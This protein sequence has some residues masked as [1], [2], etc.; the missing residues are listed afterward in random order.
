MTPARPANWWGQALKAFLLILAVSSSSSPL[1]AIVRAS[2]EPAHPTNQQTVTFVAVSPGAQRITLGFEL[3]RLSQNPNGSRQQ[4]QVSAFREVATCQAPSNG[5]CRHPMASAFPAASLVRFRATAVNAQGLSET[6]T[7]DFAAGAY[8]WPE[9]PIPVRVKG[10]PIDRF[11]VVFI[12]DRDI[13]VESF[14]SQ[15]TSVVRDRYFKYPIIETGRGFYNFYYSGQQGDYENG[16]A[17]TNP[18]NMANL[19]AVADAV[20]FLH[21]ADL[22]DCKFGR[23]VSSE[24]NNDKSMIHETGH[25]LFGLQD[26]YCC[27]S[28]YSPQACVPNLWS[29]EQRCKTAAP[30][31]G[32]PANSCVQLAEG[33]AK[34]AL[35]RIGSDG[36]AGCI[37]GPSQHRPGSNFGRACMRRINRKYSRC[38]AGDCSQSECD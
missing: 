1:G 17:F 15:L 3:F 12:P 5:E 4:T 31:I 18:S 23:R 28:S 24:I 36:D 35:W 16:C 10:R 37:M 11:D 6:E 27:D 7:Y 33:G 8:P 22:R 32:Q 2:H 19:T 25:I 38:Q 21:I 9:D 30:T 34:L 13:S 29:S 14:R 26:E 20:V